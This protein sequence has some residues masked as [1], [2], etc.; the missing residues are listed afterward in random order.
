[1]HRVFV[2]IGR[3]SVHLGEAFY[4]SNRGEIACLGTLPNG[5]LRVVLLVPAGLA[6]HQGLSGTPVTSQVPAQ[7][8]AIGVPDPRDNLTSI[9]GQLAARTYPRQQP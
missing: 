9:L 6:A 1:M 3:F 7:Q 2:L 5:D 4:I 8:G